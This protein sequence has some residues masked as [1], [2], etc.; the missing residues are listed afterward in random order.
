VAVSLPASGDAPCQLQL[1]SLER[2]H[3]QMFCFKAPSLHEKVR[4]TRNFG[5]LT[6]CRNEVCPV[7]SPLCVQGAVQMSQADDSTAVLASADGDENTVRP[8]AVKAAKRRK[9]SKR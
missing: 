6:A 4:G 8:P 1:L 3:E 7:T 5:L 2:H 9:A